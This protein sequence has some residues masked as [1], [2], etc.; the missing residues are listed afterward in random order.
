MVVLWVG[1]EYADRLELRRLA[2]T[3]LAASNPRMTGTLLRCLVVAGFSA[4]VL[5]GPIAAGGAEPQV[6]GALQAV[7]GDPV[8]VLWVASTGGSAACVRSG[9]PVSYAA[10]ATAGNVC[11]SGP[12][13][14]ARASKETWC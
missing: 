10:A 2:R 4:L 14:Y 8:A 7:K 12:T 9:E 11:D 5:L 13:A 1:M 6:T 3:W